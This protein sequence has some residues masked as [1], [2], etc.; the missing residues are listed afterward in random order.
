[1]KPTTDIRSD[2][3]WVQLIN[4]DADSLQRDYEQIVKWMPTMFQVTEPGN[5]VPDPKEND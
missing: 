3:G 5:E 4:E 1:M 2:A